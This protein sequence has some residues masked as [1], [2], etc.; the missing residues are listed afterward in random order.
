MEKRPLRFHRRPKDP[1]IDDR[2]DASA[3]STLVDDVKKT[4]ET[5]QQRKN[6]ISPT[7]QQQ[8]RHW[9]QQTAVHDGNSND[10]NNGRTTEWLRRHYD[11]D[12]LGLAMELQARRRASEQQQRRCSGC[13]N[14]G[15]TNDGINKI[16][17]GSMGSIS[18]K[19]DGKVHI[20]VSSSGSGSGT[21]SSSNNDSG[22]GSNAL[23]Q[24]SMESDNGSDNKD[25]ND[26]NGS[27]ALW[28]QWQQLQE[29]WQQLP[30]SELRRK[31]SG[32]GS[33]SNSDSRGG[34]TTL[35]QRSMESDNS[36]DHN[37]S[38][39]TNG[40]NVLWLQ[41]KQLQEQWR[42]L[43]GFE[44]R[45]RYNNDNEGGTESEECNSGKDSV[46]QIN[47][48]GDGNGGSGCLHTQYNDN[49]NDNN[50]NC[51]KCDGGL[52]GSHG[53]D[54]LHGLDGPNGLDG[55]DGSDGLDGLYGLDTL[56]CLDCSDGS[57][58]SGGSSDN[59]CNDD[60]YKGRLLEDLYDI[61]EVDDSVK[62]KVKRL[63]QMEDADIDWYLKDVFVDAL[64]NANNWYDELKQQQGN[65]VYGDD[66]IFVC[67]PWWKSEQL[68]TK[69]CSTF[70]V[71]NAERC[72]GKMVMNNE[73]LVKESQQ[74]LNSYTKIYKYQHDQYIK[75]KKKTAQVC[76]TVLVKDFFKIFE[77][78]GSDDDTAVS[79]SSAST[80]KHAIEA[81]IT[82]ATV[83]P[84][85]VDLVEPRAARQCMA[86]RMK[87]NYKHRTNASRMK[88]QPSTRPRPTK[89]TKKST[90]ATK[91]RTRM[92][93]RIKGATTRSSG[94]RARVWDTARME[95]EGGGGPMRT[96]RFR[97]KSA[98]VWDT[99]RTEREGGGSPM[100]TTR[101]RNNDMNNRS[102]RF[103][104]KKT[105]TITYKRI[106]SLSRLLNN[107]I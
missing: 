93:T 86:A 64:D 31:Y 50:S 88:Q 81:T 100:K 84:A 77:V 43:P 38:N 25:S 4:T 76:G 28:L 9:Q 91:T 19:S 6:G 56:D 12:R 90:R 22:D 11:G 53:L 95:R 40:S 70:K 10:N 39:D 72:S 57:D 79:E 59:S 46:D 8:Q 102:D 34:S 71:K 101:F 99:A 105:N 2:L 51:G 96:T 44:L 62:D 69:V 58:G 92:A 41:W 67:P 37:D 18:S 3:V 75:K 21:G 45:R 47:T 94:E 82:G 73:E 74:A 66:G 1:G 24:H 87:N 15:S 107:V 27:N 104:S 60:G 65:M 33:S 14:A 54:S 83:D 17:N 23:N 103:G 42:Q 49:N 85:L 80:S 13:D 30:G 61:L 97:K 78:I 48:I 98:R 68:L 5:T 55:S 52:D 63:M 106:F 35:N 26:T 32:T 7:E 20:S 16:G 29:Q 89:A 36:S